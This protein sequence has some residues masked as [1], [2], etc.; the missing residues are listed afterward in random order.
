MK[1]TG[2]LVNAGQT[3]YSNPNG[4]IQE[5]LYESFRSIIN[6][7]WDLV[8]SEWVFDDKTNNTF[9]S[10]GNI[11]LRLDSVWR[12]TGEK[13]EWLIE[14][15]NEANVNAS[16]KISD[17]VLTNWKYNGD[18]NFIYEKTK[19]L[20]TY[21]DKLEL[22][23]QTREIWD[24]E[25]QVWVKS[26]KVEFA[27]DAEGR[28]VLHTIYDSF[29]PSTSQWN[30]IRKMEWAYNADGSQALYAT[31]DWIPPLMSWRLSYKYEYVI[32][33][34]GV[35]LLESVTQWNSNLAAEIIQYKDEK[36]FDD[37]RNLTMESYIQTNIY[38]EGSQQYVYTEGEKIEYAYDTSNRLV[39]LTEYEYFQDVFVPEEKYEYTYDTTYPSALDFEILYKWN[40][41]WLKDRKGVLTNDFN[42]TRSDLILPFGD[43]DGSREVSMYFNYM[44][45][46][47]LEYKWVEDND[48]GDWVE[49]FKANLFFSQSEFSAVDKV[50][51]SIVSVYPNPVSDYLQ[52]RLNENSGVANF[53]LFDIQGKML[54]QVPVHNQL[55]VDLSRYQ[56]GLYFY[57]LTMD[58]ETVSGKLWKK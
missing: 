55:T 53:K 8:N 16:G 18:T 9:D 11:T 15:S 43:D 40:D 54:Y 6:Y 4:E 50:N 56:N 2:Q 39:S 45:T 3:V 22:I 20:N 52:V 19:F 23:A 17:Y 47:M 49:D 38:W 25:Y 21:N 51:E 13:N 35:I 28:E 33:D 42:V 1:P 27:Y 12:N 26:A 41:G 14:F 29:N 36:T 44:A 10:F 5:D 34:Q 37:Q 24:F 46:Q 48:S 32:D 31:Y 7:E 30:P 58:N 57:Q